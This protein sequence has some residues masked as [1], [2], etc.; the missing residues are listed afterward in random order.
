MPTY[1]PLL[2]HY[3]LIHLAGA[4]A[5]CAGVACVCAVLWRIRM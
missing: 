2:L 1:D 5:K 4:V 3:L